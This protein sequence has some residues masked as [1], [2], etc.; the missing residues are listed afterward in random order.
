MYSLSAAMWSAESGYPECRLNIKMSS[1]SCRN[2]Y[3]KNKTFSWPYYLCY[4]NHDTCKDGLHIETR[5]GAICSQSARSRTRAGWIF[6]PLESA[7][8]I[9][10]NWIILTSNNVLDTHAYVLYRYMHDQN[11]VNWIL[12]KHVSNI[13]SGS[14][15]LNT[16]FVPQYMN[17][18]F[19]YQLFL[20]LYLFSMTYSVCSFLFAPIIVSFECLRHVLYWELLVIIYVVLRP[21]GEDISSD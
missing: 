3:H 21:C 1:H 18:R 5:P 2:S 11:L 7:A 20:C 6:R 17:F 12:P 9:I 13:M 14:Q 4:G 19:L 16:I 10:E 15:S 8:G